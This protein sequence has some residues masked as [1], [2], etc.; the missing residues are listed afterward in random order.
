MLIVAPE[1]GD[2]V[3]R[4][5]SVAANETGAYTLRAL[6][7]EVEERGLKAAFIALLPTP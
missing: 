4:A 3:V 2:L 7:A 1:A 5:N 6:P